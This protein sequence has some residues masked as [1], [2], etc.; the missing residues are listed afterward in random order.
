MMLLLQCELF[1]HIIYIMADNI[2]EMKACKHC[3]TSFTITDKDVEFYNKIS[4]IFAWKKYPIPTPTLCQDCRQQRRL[5]FRNERKLY[6]RTCDA[7]GKQIISMYSPDKPYKIYDQ[8]IRWSDSWN[9]M[10]YGKEYDFTKPF[11]E[12]F[13]ELY[14][15]IPKISLTNTGSENSEYVNYSRWLKDCYLCFWLGQS[16]NS[17]YIQTGREDKNC[18]DCSYVTWCQQCYELVDSHQCFDTHF[19]QRCTN[20]NNLS[21]CIDMENCSF[22]TFCV[23][24]VNASYGILNELYDKDT[25]FKKLQEI[26]QNKEIYQKQFKELYLKTPKKYGQFIQTDNCTW[27]VLLWSKNSEYCFDSISLENCKYVSSSWW[28]KDSYDCTSINIWTNLMYQAQGAWWFKSIFINDSMSLTES[29]YCDQCFDSK[30]LFG[31]IGLRTKEFCILNKQYTKEE[32]EILLPKIIEHMEKTWERGDFFSNDIS[33]FSYNETIA[34]EY[35][36]LDRAWALSLWCKRMDQE[37]PIN[38]PENAQTIKAHDLSDNINDITDDILNQV[39]I[40]EFTWKPFRII[41]PE[42][43]FYRKHNLPIPH[44]HPDQRHRERMLL[45]NPR[46]LRKRVCAK[47]WETIHTSYA[48]ERPEIIYCESCYNKEIY[49]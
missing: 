45:R 41:K 48:P 19:S 36:P 17:Y 27:N 47:C 4:P 1:Y 29:M 10:D 30:N 43:E 34:Q 39:I 44:K 31:C 42:L 8:K 2:V 32:Y 14:Q 9:A 23:W 24:L 49:G 20:S 40:C 28:S 25:Y 26:S 18:V 16:E 35:Y 6:K 7:S 22:C 3:W 13:K 37:Y 21:H 11:F 5:S 38:I 46:K 12:Q 15:Y 33:V